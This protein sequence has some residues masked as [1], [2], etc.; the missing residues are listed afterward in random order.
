MSGEGDGRDTRG[1]CGMSVKLAGWR[2]PAPPVSWPAKEAVIQF[3]SAILRL[4]NGPFRIALT[5][6]RVVNSPTGLE[7][8]PSLTPDFGSVGGNALNLNWITASKAG[9]PRLAVL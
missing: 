7:K 8:R 4:Q 6:S 9:H 1:L 5:S 3:P 2:H